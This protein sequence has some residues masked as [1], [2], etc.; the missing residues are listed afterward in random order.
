MTTSPK[1][2]KVVS[3]V[4]IHPPVSFAAIVYKRKGIVSITEFSENRK[5]RTKPNLEIT[6]E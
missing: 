4:D 2:L 6:G 5:Q 1:S 3:D